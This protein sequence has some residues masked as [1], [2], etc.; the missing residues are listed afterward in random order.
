M[1]ENQ[2]QAAR[3]QFASSTLGYVFSDPALLT[4]ALTHRSLVNEAQPHQALRHNERLEFL[5]DAV[6]GMLVAEWLMRQLPDADEGELTRLRASLVCMNGLAG[7]ARSID[8]GRHLL[9]GH[10]EEVSG[11]RDKDSLL[12][13]ALEAIVGAVFLDGGL[14]ACRRVVHHLLAESLAQLPENRHDLDAKSLLQQRLQK[15]HGTMPRYRVVGESGPDHLP[16]FTVEV[17]ADERS[18]GSGRGRSKKEAEQAAAAEAL[19]NLPPP[20]TTRPEDK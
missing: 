3:Q 11:G 15:H 9:L 7:V 5:G 14:S 13:D 6:L 19:Q 17:L 20:G 2:Q 8:L 10:G 1:N 4:E 18:L 12:A 16:T